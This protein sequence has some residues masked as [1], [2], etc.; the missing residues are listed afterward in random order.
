MVFQVGRVVF[1]WLSDRKFINRLMLYNTALTLCGICTAL[2][3]LCTTYPWL[4]AYSA[5]YGLFI[6][7]WGEMF[8]AYRCRIQ[9]SFN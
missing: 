1:G 6:G 2:S 5:S 3:A 8:S 4:V 7:R 9:M